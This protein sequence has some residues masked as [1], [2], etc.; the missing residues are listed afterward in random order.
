MNPK[1]KQILDQ[2]PEQPGCYLWKNVHNQIIYIGKAKNLKK[3]T[4]QY[5]NKAHNYRISKLV[6]EIADVDYIVVQNENESLILENNLIKE[7]KPQYNILLKEGSN[8]YPYIVVTDEKYPRILYTRVF[9]RYKGVHYGPFANNMTSNA[10]ELYLLL[11]KL[12]PLRK[13]KKLPYKECMYYHMQQCLG[14]CIHQ[15]EHGDFDQYRKEIDDIFKNRPNETIKALQAKE[16]EAASKL[17]FELAKVYFNYVSQLKNICNNQIAQLK[18]I[19]DA[20][21]IGYFTKENYVCI[22]IF[23]YIDGKL[24]VKHE[25]ISEYYDDLEEVILSYLTQFY[26]GHNVPK[27]V[28]INLS[29]ENSKLLAEYLNAKVI[30]PQIGTYLNLIT[31]AINN[32][33][34]YLA[35]NELKIQHTYDRGFG[36][37]EKLGQ[38]L[39][40]DGLNH[41]ELIDNSNLFL[42][43]CVSAVIV[44]KNA[45]PNKR[46]Y[47]KYI[48]RTTEEKSDYYF[49][50][51]VITRRYSKLIEFP[52]LLIVDGGPLQVSIAV[53]TLT[54]LG[55]S[56]VIKVAGLVKNDK[57][58]TDALTLA[59]NTLIPLDKHSPLYH[60]LASMQNEVHRYVITFFRNKS[61]QSKLTNFLDDIEGL[62][63]KSKHKLL[64]IYPNIY[65]LKDVSVETIAQIIS[66]KA[67]INLKEKL[68][69]EIK[70]D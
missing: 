17:Q 55:L 44:Y 34:E 11:N 8:S 62:G 64:T 15:L 50:K 65:D 52:Q 12:F 47:R 68:A 45:L 5:F 6:S 61:T 38:L 56:D 40:I 32:A 69:K 51:E 18:Q 25:F 27:T 24:L 31:N 58:Q 49:M 1:I 35:K 20:D 60:F 46:L 10:Y 37:Q 4:N 26:E 9:G 43:D 66:K 7:H 59:D 67:A 30:K 22:N 63:E 70:N 29:S 2:I 36:A 3:R 48:L 41:I 23:N 42:E 16:L 28:Y 54:E 14:P 19:L 53:K 39:G 57:H 21:I 33:K 13:C